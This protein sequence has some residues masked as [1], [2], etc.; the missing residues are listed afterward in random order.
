MTPRPPAGAAAPDPVA[1]AIRREA[2]RLARSLEAL[3]ALQRALPA[4]G[5]E[6]LAALLR[7]ERP[8]GLAAYRIGRLHWAAA[9]IEAA[10]LDLRDLA[11]PETGRWLLA[12]HQQGRLPGDETLR[13]L[14]GALAPPTPGEGE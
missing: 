6:E 12:L 8:F 5:P 11:R 7:G 10:V 14:A 2:S 4:P 1:R 9:Q 13:Y 3:E